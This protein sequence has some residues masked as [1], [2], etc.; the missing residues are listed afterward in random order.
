MKILPSSWINDVTL[1]WK[2]DLL[3]FVP[4]ILLMRNCPV[5]WDLTFT[6]GETFWKFV[7]VP[8]QGAIL[9]VKEGKK[10]KKKE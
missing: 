5:E 10:K 7:N 9:N 1:L 4:K 6:M 3:T 8:K 2:C